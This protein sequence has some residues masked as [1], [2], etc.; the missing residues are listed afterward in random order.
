MQISH[1]RLEETAPQ[2]FAK[3]NHERFYSIGDFAPS[4]TRRFQPTDRQKQRRA[5]DA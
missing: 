5:A 4:L 2:S 3:S 1:G